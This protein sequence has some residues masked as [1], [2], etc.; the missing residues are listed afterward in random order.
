MQIEYAYFSETPVFQH[1]KHDSHKHIKDN[2]EALI[3]AYENKKI[4]CEEEAQRNHENIVKDTA[5]FMNK[6]CRY[7]NSSLRFISGYGFWGCPNYKDKSTTHS[8][9]NEEYGVAE[10]YITISTHWIPEIISDCGLKGLVKAKDLFNWYT[11]QGLQDLRVLFGKSPSANSINS[12]VKTKI[13]ST[14]QEQQAYDLLKSMF[15]KV[16]S[17][18]CITYKIKGEKQSFCI[19]DFI[20]GNS[21]G[22]LV[23]DAKLD[24]PNDEKMELYTALVKYIMDKKS[25]MRP[26]DGAHV[27]YDSPYLPKTPKFKL[28]ILK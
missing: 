24:C 10:P 11:E 8:T 15:V 16:V 6:R 23:A 5:A 22:V 25:D 7:C 4:K 13:K 21:D 9:F 27:M 26:V 18:Q 1:G 28:F 17:Q 12:Y 19:P 14:R 3:L 20:C 2:A